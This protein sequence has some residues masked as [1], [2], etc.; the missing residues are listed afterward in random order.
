MT[1]YKNCT[2]FA[3]ACGMTKIACFMKITLNYDV[4]NYMVCQHILFKSLKSVSHTG[5]IAPNMLKTLRKS[6]DEDLLLTSGTSKIEAQ[7]LEVVHRM[8]DA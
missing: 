2:V 3:V 7:E 5:G 8:S 1:T 4:S 6:V